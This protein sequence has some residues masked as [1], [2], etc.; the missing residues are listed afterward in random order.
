MVKPERRERRM[1]PFKA[2]LLVDDGGTYL[3]SLHLERHQAASK[4]ELW[5][6]VKDTK[7]R[8][9]RVEIREVK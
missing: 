9:I 4:R 5:R 1:K 6:D 3:R 8:I 7:W 2:W